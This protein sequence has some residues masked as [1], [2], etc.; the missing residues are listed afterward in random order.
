MFRTIA[1]ALLLSSC[2]GRGENPPAQPE[3]GRPGE[4]VLTLAE[5]ASPPREV[6]DKR[7]DEVSWGG[8][9]VVLIRCSP[10]RAEDMDRLLETLRRQPGVVSAEPNQ[11]RTKR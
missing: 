1:L 11:M 4:V 10:V 3:D 8:E 2:T 9:R 6:E 5:G 7:C